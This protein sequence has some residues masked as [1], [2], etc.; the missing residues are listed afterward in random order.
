VSSTQSI[1]GIQEGI[2]K[3]LAIKYSWNQ[4]YCSRNP[5][6]GPSIFMPMHLSKPRM[7]YIV[8]RI[9]IIHNSGCI[10]PSWQDYSHNSCFN[11]SNIILYQF[12]IPYI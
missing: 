4:N 12:C 8:D 6:M 10:L 5:I 9:R 1:T 11:Y 2:T 7:Q 3:L